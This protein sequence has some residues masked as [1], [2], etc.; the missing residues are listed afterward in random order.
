MHKYWIMLLLAGFFTL[1]SPSC[2]KKIGCP[3]NEDTTPKFDGSKA[4]KT[5]TKSGLVGKSKKYKKR[6]N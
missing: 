3:V 4:K 6:R 5:K 1:L 2:T